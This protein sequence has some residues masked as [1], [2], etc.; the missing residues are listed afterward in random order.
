MRGRRSAAMP[1]GFDRR[2]FLETVIRHLNDLRGQTWN[3]LSPLAS[4][5]IELFDDCMLS[6]CERHDS[7]VDAWTKALVMKA[8]VET[9]DDA[10]ADYRKKLQE[11]AGFWPMVKSRWQLN[12]WDLGRDL[13]AELPKYLGAQPVCTG[14]QFET[15]RRAIVELSPEQVF[16]E[17]Y[18]RLL[19]EPYMVSAFEER[20]EALRFANALLHL[21]L[22][23]WPKPAQ[24]VDPWAP[25][26]APGQEEGSTAQE[27]FFGPGSGAWLKAVAKL[28][29]PPPGDAATSAGEAS[30]SAETRPSVTL[31]RLQL[32]GTRR[33]SRRA[34]A[35]GINAPRRLRS[36][37]RAKAS[38]VQGDA[39]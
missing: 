31:P 36:G 4:L 18:C 24:G 14:E 37:N 9:E 28:E 33:A 20:S 26:V 13:E 35:R 16:G 1:P 23:H 12:C 10:L 5:L 34:A 27:V 11:D 30:Q 21:C 39:S 2:A 19:D 22:V 38:R 8:V 7:K 29:T 25:P 3:H 17:D 15:L 32:T 6:C